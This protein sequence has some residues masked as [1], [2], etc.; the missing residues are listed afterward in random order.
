M[1]LILIRNRVKDMDNSKH[2]MRYTDEQRNDFLELASEIGITRAMRQLK[3]PL[4]W[5]AAKGWVDAAGI[6]IPLD[7]LKAKAAAARDW[8][9]TEDLL[10][11]AQAGIQRV[12]LELQQTDLDADAHK[13]MSEA[14][15][16]Y[17][18][19][20]RLL[21]EKATSITE[22]Q[23]KDGF[24]LDV[25]DLMNAEKARNALIEKEAESETA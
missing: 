8:Y 5:T 20:W 3:Y 25:L 2:G 10:V 15:Q 16:K 18:N 17:V 24:D 4:S 12:Y 13:K 21:Q 7:E 6:T 14:F 1:P 23:H 19:S 22:T 11:V 9:T